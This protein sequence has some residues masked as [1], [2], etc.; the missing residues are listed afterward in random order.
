LP[1]GP[2][3]NPCRA[4]TNKRWLGPVSCDVGSRAS[5]DPGPCFSQPSIALALGTHL[6][7]EV[8]LTPRQKKLAEARFELLLLADYDSPVHL[9]DKDDVRHMKTLERRGLVEQRPGQKMWRR[10][11][12]GDDLL[13]KLS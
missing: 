8:R 1:K 9:D 4:D 13:G 5:K 7:K 10:T 6:R 11:Q 12:A 2:F 3:P